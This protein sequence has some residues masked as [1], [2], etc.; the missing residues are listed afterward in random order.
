[1]SP[2]SEKVMDSTDPKSSEDTPFAPQASRYFIMK[3]LTK[4]D[5]TWSV[6]N[7]VW[8]TQPHNEG[9]LN[10]AFEVYSFTHNSDK[11]DIRK[12]LS[13]FQCQQKW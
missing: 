5:L 2:L 13:Y 10:D 7:K 8:A 3:S 4:E 9:I 1:M 12:C 6:A 11:L